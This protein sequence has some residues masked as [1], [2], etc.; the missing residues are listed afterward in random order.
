M[1]IHD[2]GYKPFTG[3][4]L[5]PSHNGIVLLRQGMARAW[6]SLLVKIAVLL[7]VGP[8]LVAAVWAFLRFRVLPAEATSGLSP[9]DAARFV[10][11]LFDWQMWIFVFAVTVGAGAAAV[12]DDVANRAFQFYFAKPVTPW[13]YVAGRV[14]AV[15]VFA[16]LFTFAP[17]FL[18][19]GLLAGMAPDVHQAVARLGLVFPVALY[20]PIVAAPFAIASVAVSALFRS[21]ALTV[22]AWIAILL[23]PHLLGA[24]LATIL[25]SGWPYVLSLPS[26]V[27]VIGDALFRLAPEGD[28]RWWH[29]APIV[30]AVCAG[31]LLYLRR[32]VASIEVIG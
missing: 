24:L 27:G 11:D 25:R 30:A 4:R 19:V 29:A 28:L 15:A 2:T 1:P 32:R 6:S 23:L 10:R 5:P 12:S 18:F 16:L 22:S 13:Q 20:A 9:P 17:A 31:G 14:G 8:V 26:L 3:V 7:C 21:R